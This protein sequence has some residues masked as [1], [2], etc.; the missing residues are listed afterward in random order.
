MPTISLFYGI[1]ILMFYDDHA[2]AHFHAE[3]GGNKALIDIV[4]VCVTKGALPKPQLLQVLSW[5]TL[6]KDELLKNWELAK[7]HCELIKIDP[8][9]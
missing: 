7:Q 1:K 3:Y 8:L 4:N 2:P 9:R 6:H 5:T